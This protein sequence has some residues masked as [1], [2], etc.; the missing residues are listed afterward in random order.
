MTIADHHLAPSVAIK[1]R[2]ESGRPV[3]AIIC[4]LLHIL[5]V[6]FHVIILV[7]NIS[8][9]EHRLVVAMTSGNEIWVTILSASS[10]A[11]YVVSYHNTYTLFGPMCTLQIY[12]TILIYL[13]Q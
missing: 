4:T 11:F 2:Q 9:I 5:L 7:L 12:C 6:V 10:Q 13:M 8:G 1:Q 3:L